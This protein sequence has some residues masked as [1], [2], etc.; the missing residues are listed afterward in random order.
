[1][2]LKGLPID[3]S[4]PFSIYAV[5]LLHSQDW[6]NQLEGRLTTYNLTLP[7]KTADS[8]ASSDTRKASF[9]SQT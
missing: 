3:G 4:V 7:H 2:M 1:M 5:I 8:C 6:H 9:P